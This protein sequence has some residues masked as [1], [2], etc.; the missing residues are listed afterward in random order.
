MDLSSFLGDNLVHLAR[1]ALTGRPQDVHA[2]I[3]KA[4]LRLR[5]EAPELAQQLAALLAISPS[6]NAPLRDA[7]A[8]MVPIDVD[9]KQ[10]LVRSE[11]PV[12]LREEP[13]LS[14]DVHL[15][16]GQVVAERN[17]LAKLEGRGLA[18]TRS[19]LFVGPPGVGKT[20]SARWLAAELK[21]P[22]VTL[23]LTTVMS[24]FLGKTGSNVRSVL[25]YAKSVDSVLL[26]DEFDAIA[27]RRDDDSD[28]GELK[29]LVNV[30]LQEIDDW[31][32]TS[33]LIAATNHGE[34]L[35]PAVWRR[36][37]DVIEF[38]VPSID[39]R[40]VALSRLFS[41]DEEIEP[42]LPILTELWS[43]RSHGDM[44]RT[45]QWLRRRAIVSD[46]GIIGALAERIGE[47]LRHAGPN[48]RK[49]AAMLLREA[50]FSDRR[51][52]NLFGI[53]RDTIRRNRKMAL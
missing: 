23:D 53:S 47:E 43:G 39:E 28:V 18:P 17:S 4:V 34:L 14:P 37:D 13:I 16:L 30:L 24:S 51:I 9:S 40:K 29:R 31:P 52:S 33:L 6:V 44:A 11:H 26:L 12:L 50:G 5:K 1:L 27:K 32:S 3:R 48:E 42:W 21:R 25:D 10:A 41:D 15:R 22:L 2:L 45:A 35:D 49:R 46:Q 38:Q 7:G 19:L 36:F 8:G 20:L